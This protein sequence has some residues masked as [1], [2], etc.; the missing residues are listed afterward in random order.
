MRND[1]YMRQAIE[2]ARRGTG[3]VNPNP[4]VGCVVVKDGR[5][6]AAG[7]HEHY[8][9]F[10]AERNALTRCEED[11]RGAE[12]YV[13]LEPCCHTGQTPPCTDIIME[14]GIGTVYIGSDDPNPLVAGKGVEILKKS[15]IHVETHVLKEECDRLNEIFFHYITTGRP[16]VAMKYAMTLDGKITT[17]VPAGKPE[18][19]NRAP[20]RI[21]GPEAHRHVHQLRKRYAAILVGVGTVI[22]DDPML[23]VRLDEEPPDTACDPVRVILDS[24]LRIPIESRIVRTARE[25]PTIVVYTMAERSRRSTLEKAGVRTLAVGTDEYRETDLEETFM[26][27]GEEKIDSVLVEGGSRV[28][29]SLLVHSRLVNRVYAFIA[30]RLFGGES[31][32]TPVGGPGI[33]DATEALPLTNVETIPLGE[34]LLVTGNIIG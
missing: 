27:L 28:H 12:M 9:G 32:L 25:I 34:D 16:Y 17:A 29:G 8:G 13:T 21:T 1:E 3:Y 23:N 6:A 2:L 18:I 14:R 19:P 7:W 10:H 20:V 33:T 24:H 31:A 15:G 4:L 11:L 5:V 30:P 22:A 26:R